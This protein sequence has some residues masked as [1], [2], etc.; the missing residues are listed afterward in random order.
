MKGRVARTNTIAVAMKSVAYLDNDEFD[1]RM[2]IVGE[3]FEAVKSGSGS[4]DAWGDLGVAY[5]ILVILANERGVLS[6]QPIEFCRVV[7]ETM[8]EAYAEF[9]ADRDCRPTEGQIEVIQA[10]VDLYRSALES[11]PCRL[12]NK[13]EMGVNARIQSNTGVL[14]FTQSASPKKVS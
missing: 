7:A 6:G 10:M 2:K 5:N 1:S 9:C 14:D 12:I 11:V 3:A 4:D 8:K 13:A